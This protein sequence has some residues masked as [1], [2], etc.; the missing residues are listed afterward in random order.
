MLRGYVKTEAK[1]TAELLL[2]SELGDPVLARWHYGLGRVAILTTQLGRRLGARI[3]STGRPHPDMMANLIRQLGGVSPRQPLA[4][5]ID[6]SSAGLDLG[7]R[8]LSPDP[9]L[10]AAPLRV[11][12]KD[13]E[14]RADRDPRSHAGARPH[15]E[16]L[17]RG[18]SRRRFPGRGDGCRRGK[19][20]RHRRGG[21]AAAERIHPRRARP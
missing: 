5:T 12:V 16:T 6:W 9:S 7:I 11:V 20:A 8:A 10:A 1:D 18:S 17:V 13:A 19:G 14:W 15:W 21:G 2:R 3:S 4:L